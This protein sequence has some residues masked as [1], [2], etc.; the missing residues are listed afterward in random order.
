LNNEN[1][2][3]SLV[4]LGFTRLEADIYAFLLGASPATGY[5]ISQVIGKPAA[6]VYN[7]LQSLEKKGAVLVEETTARRC[8]AVPVEELSARMHRRFLDTKTAL[9]TA[10]SGSDPAQGDNRIYPLRSGE[11]VFEKCRR[12]LDAAREVV[13]VDAFPG[14]LDALKGEIEKAAS[15]RVRVAVNAYM[16]VQIGGVL[17][18]ERPDG[19]RVIARWPGEWINMVKDGEE[20]VQALLERNLRGVIQAVWSGSPYL[21]WVYYSALMSE[22]ELGGLRRRMMENAGIAGLREYVESCER[23]FPLEAPGYVRLMEQLFK[24]KTKEKGK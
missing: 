2:I 8:R 3:Q 12:M 18:F 6:N 20:Y 13:L 22:L 23:F 16:P 7:A 24:V 15:R 1:G 9:E 14:A 5:R 17:L 21:S 11:Q 4:E 19:A 10:F